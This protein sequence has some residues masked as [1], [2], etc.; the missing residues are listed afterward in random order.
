[1]S[2]AHPQRQ[3]QAV[4]ADHTGGVMVPT[5]TMRSGTRTHRRSSSLPLLKDWVDRPKARSDALRL[6]V[7]WQSQHATRGAGMC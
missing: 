7:A 5:S 1:M 3:F 6:S 2:F 4:C